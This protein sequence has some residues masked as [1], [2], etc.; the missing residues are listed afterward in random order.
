MWKESK[1]K[2][3]CYFDGHASSLHLYSAIQ[4]NVTTLLHTLFFLNGLSYF[5][6]TELENSVMKEKREKN[7]KLLPLHKLARAC[8][9]T[10][11]ERRVGELSISH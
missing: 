2:K 1:K 5:G 4:S 10:T 7:K 11:R 8:V 6:I 3:N 9:K